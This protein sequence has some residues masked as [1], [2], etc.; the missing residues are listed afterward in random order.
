MRKEYITPAIDTVIMSSETFCA[1]SGELGGTPHIMVSNDEAD[2]GLD[3][4][5]KSHVFDL[6]DEEEED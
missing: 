6:D 5:G 3:A 2:Y 1:A 4:L